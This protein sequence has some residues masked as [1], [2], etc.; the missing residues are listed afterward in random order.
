M[1]GVSESEDKEEGEEKMNRGK[2]GRRKEGGWE[3]SID[4]KEGKGTFK[5]KGD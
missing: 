3:R 5:G 2:K 4:G 1:E